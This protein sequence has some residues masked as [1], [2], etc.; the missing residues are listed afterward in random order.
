MNF[1]ESQDIAKRNTVKLIVLF[2]LAILSLVVITNILVM[3]VFGLLSVNS[4]SLAEGVAF[5]RGPAAF[6][7]YVYR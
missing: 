7:C 4:A 1:F 6:R 2:V 5:F 3:V